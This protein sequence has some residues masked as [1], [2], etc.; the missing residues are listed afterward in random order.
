MARPLW[1][2]MGS[3]LAVAACQQGSQK[4][5]GEGSEHT[6]VLNQGK[7]GVPRGQAP[8]RAPHHSQEQKPRDGAMAQR[9]PGR[10]TQTV[11]ALCGAAPEYGLPL[12]CLPTPEPLALLLPLPVSGREPSSLQN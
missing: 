11:A 5:Q 1:G 10:A 2:V 9:E 7:V 8:E 6:D 3:L 4:G 12:F